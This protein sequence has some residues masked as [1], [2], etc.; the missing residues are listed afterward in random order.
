MKAVLL[1]VVVLLPCVVLAGDVVN[2]SPKVYSTRS[3]CEG[4]HLSAAIDVYKPVTCLTTRIHVDEHVSV[5][6]HYQM[7]MGTGTGKDFHSK[8]LINYA[9]SGSIFHSGVHYYKNPTGFYMANLSPGYYTIEVHYKSPVA[10]NVR[11]SW[12][13]QTAVLQAMWFRD[14]Q[15]V[16]STIKCYPTPITTNSYNNM[17]PLKDLEVALQIPNTRV[18][19]SAYQLSAELVS[20]DYI[21][22]ALNV[23]GFYQKSSAFLR[24]PY[25]SLHLHGLW[26]DNHRTGIHYFNMLYRTPVN[27]SFTDCGA[28][29][30]GLDIKN[31]YAM[32]LPTSCKVFKVSPESSFS[33]VTNNLWAATD[34][35]YSLVLSKQSHV[36]IMYQYAG[37][38]GG[39]APRSHFVT[40]LSIN[41]VPLK[42]TVAHSADTTYVGNFGM[43]QGPLATGIH[44]LALEYRTPKALGIHPA[45]TD[46]QTRTMT[47][48]SCTS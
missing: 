45:K 39:T 25:N 15:T 14:A 27:F 10:V 5:F 22:T 1:L 46:W 13:S 35:T 47:I 18:I 8:L 48:I 17:G 11:A 40:R 36:I 31:L 30:E 6:I 4:L 2:V 37:Y 9:N 28:E 38:G 24:G 26:A 21:V 7:I 33:P 3:T 41:C 42:H 43:W 19:L 20:P 44:K 16:S 23:N 32:M 34:V 12:D 29:A